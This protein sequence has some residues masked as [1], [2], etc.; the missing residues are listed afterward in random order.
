MLNF[1]QIPLLSTNRAYHPNYKAVLDRATVL[2]YTHP[3]ANVRSKQNGLMVALVNTGIWDELDMIKIFAGDQQNFSTIDWKGLTAYRATLS[4]TPTFT[5]NEGWTTD[6]STN[7]ID[8]N[9]SPGANGVKYATNDACFFLYNKKEITPATSFDAGVNDL[10]VVGSTLLSTRRSGTNSALYNINGT[11]G[12]FS[13]LTTYTS[14]IGFYVIKRTDASTIELFKDD[15]S[16]GTKTI[17]SSG[18]SN[19]KVYLGGR[20][21]NGSINNRADGKYA[22][23]GAGSSSIDHVTLRSLLDNY[24]NS[25]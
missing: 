12:Q 3:S 5:A 18:K 24:Y 21:D 22:F 23:V 14:S 10:G 2:G 19:L 20:N 16:D 17:A 1:A 4:G 25:L 9:W 6:A 15:V 8:L 7:Y 11:S 13:I